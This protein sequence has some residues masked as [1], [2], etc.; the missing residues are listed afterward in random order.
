MKLLLI[1]GSNIVMR[2]AFGGDIPPDKSTPIATGL[3]S[4]AARMAEAT[5]LIVALDSPDPSWRHREYLDYKA[6]RTRDTAPWLTAAYEAWT[7]LGWYVDA[8]GGYEADDIIATLAHRVGGR[9][10]VTVCSSD[11]DLLCLTA[12][13]GVTYLKPVNGGKFEVITPQA[14]QDKYKLQSPALLPD[15]K[16]LVGES[17]DNVPGVPGIGP[18]RAA[19][20]LEAYG[21]LEAILAAGREK[22]CP[23]SITV[24][25][26]EARARLALKLV[27]LV[28]DAPVLAV[29][30]S[31]CAITFEPQPA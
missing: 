14:V 11:S 13:A 25:T 3:I 24:A 20:L 19:K 9:V 23:A 18:V 31:Q 21:N 30:P 6:D 17:G 5:H 22:K 10:P 16:A 15:Y 7:R 26:H 4:R 8:T 12:L 28:T 2:A 27:T 29:K 1:D